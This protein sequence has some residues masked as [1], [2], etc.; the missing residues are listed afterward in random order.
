MGNKTLEFISAPNLHWPDTI[1]TYLKE[2]KLLFT[3]D[4]FGCHYADER[5]IDNEVGNFDEDSN[6]ILM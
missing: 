5:M 1:Y 6:I 3:C 4:S 2:D